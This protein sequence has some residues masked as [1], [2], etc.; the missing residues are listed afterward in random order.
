VKLTHTRTAKYLGRCAAMALAPL[1]LA[2]SVAQPALADNLGFTGQ[3]VYDN[4]VDTETFTIMTGG[5]HLFDSKSYA[6]GTLVNGIMV[7]RG[8]FDPILTLFAGSS[9]TGAALAFDDDGPAGSVATDPKTGQ[10]WDSFFEIWLAPGQYTVAVS[11]Y[12]NF[13]VGGGAFTFPF[14]PANNFTSALCTNQ[15]FCDV[16][17]AA[18]WNNRTNQYGWE[19]RAVPEAATWAMMVVGFG[20]VGFGMRSRTRQTLANARMV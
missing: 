16:S 13:Y 15:S 20:G 17:G 7:P 18:P 11:Q 10:A 1:L 14:P 6:G 3:L 8:G 2:A 9:A 12:N 4:E 5:L 19:L